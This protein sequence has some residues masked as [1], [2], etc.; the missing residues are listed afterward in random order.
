MSVLQDMGSARADQLNAAILQYVEAAES[1][2]SSTRA[3]LLKEYPDLRSDL[4]SFIAG[5]EGIARLAQPLR[6]AL[7]DECAQSRADRSGEPSDVGQ[8]GDFR[9]LRELGR[10]GMGV[11]YEAEQLSL[12]RRVA[13]KVLPFAAAIDTRQ[14]QRFRNEALAAAHLQH[15]HIVPVFAVGSDQGVPFYAMQF[16]D[17]QSLAQLI[18]ERRCPASCMRGS[19]QQ[20]YFR[21]VA[22][23]GRQAALALDHAHRAGIVHRDIKPANLLLDSRGHLWVTD[24]GLA[25]FGAD[26]GLTRSGEVLGTLRYTSPEQALA[27]RGVVD[28]R[29][30]IYSLGATLY[31]LASF[32]PIFD[33]RDRNALVRQIADEEPVLLRRVNAAVPEDLETIIQKAVAKEPRDRYAT[34]LDV[35]DD[36]E[37]FLEDRP[38]RAR[39]PTLVQKSGKWARRHRA[40]VGLALAMLLITMAGLVI[41]TIL[42]G[43]AYARER[44]NAREAEVQWA[45]AEANFRQAR[46]AVDRFAH[47]G[48]QDLVGRLQPEPCRRRLLETALAYYRDFLEQCPDDPRTQAELAAGR[49]RVEIILKNLATLAGAAWYFP[50]RIREVQDELGLSPEKRE[51]L[52]RIT[53]RWRDAFDESFSQDAE[54]WERRRLAL[55]QDQEAELRRLLSSKEMKRFQQIALQLAGTRAFSS[56]LVAQKLELTPHQRDR[57]R[58]LQDRVRPSVPIFGL[59]PDSGRIDP[60]EE[61]RR[62]EVRGQFAQTKQQILELLTPEQKAKWTKLVGKPLSSAVAPSA[63]SRSSSR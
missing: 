50:L 52:A 32:R 24:F 63:S 43:R 48:E 45:R 29:S 34:A 33:G 17:G 28:Q 12:R 31:E 40:M 2:R 14:R 35:A 36:F 15:P 60:A 6:G 39:R 20:G 18:D 9:L 30:D 25:R 4:E 41:A 11:V 16:V 3:R 8:L 42:I 46:Q 5:H 37:R 7:A 10:G 38:I 1:R 49:T 61:A 44:Q 59:R 26:A 56:P 54:T 27:R 22:E 19:G 21:W 57:I 62:R 53:T 23:L 58:A 55:A 51:A 47:I 13:L